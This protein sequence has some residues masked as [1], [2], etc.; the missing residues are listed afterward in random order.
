MVIKWLRL[1]NCLII[2]SQAS[3]NITCYFREANRIG[4]GAMEQRSRFLGQWWTPD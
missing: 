4:F 3:I 2:D 1:W